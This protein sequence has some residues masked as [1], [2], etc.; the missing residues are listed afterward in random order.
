MR[1]CI[2]RHVLAD[3]VLAD[4]DPIQ[5]LDIGGADVNGSYRSLFGVM[6]CA[7]TTADIADDPSVDLVL[8]GSCELPFDD[9]AFDVVVSGQTFEHVG[10]FW[11]LFAE[12]MRVCSRDG[13]V[14]VIAPST[15]FEHRYPVDCYRFLPDSYASLAEKH[16][17]MLI[18][19]WLDER[20]PFCD[21]VGI[22]RHTPAPTERREVP[23]FLVAL[24]GGLQNDTPEIEIAEVEVAAGA[25]G[26]IKFLQQVHAT[27]EPRFYLEV[28][29]FDGASLHQ[30]RCPALGIDPDPAVRFKL[31]DDQRVHVALS[32]DAFRD[33]EVLEALG[34][35]DLVYIDGMHLIEN[36]YEDFCHVERL[37]HGAS[38]ILIDDVFPNHPH[39]ARR[40]RSSRHWTGD[41]WKIIRILRLARPD[42]VLLP[43]DVSPTGCLMVIGADPE[44]RSLW[45]GF[46]FILAEAVE[47]TEDPPVHILDRHRALDPADPLIWRVLRMIRD[48]RDAATAT[49]P[50][51]LT[52]LRALVNGAMP[53]R[54]TPSTPG[55]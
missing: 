28:G 13:I 55:S 7:Y 19:H 18:D 35:L 10:P 52:A 53:R 47:M 31:R 21:L 2:R 32:N 40:Q 4:R 16:G 14:V 27:L 25:L 38:V 33:P 26:A 5:V 17:V 8:D 6:P 24:D 46:D 1:R 34:P 45:D 44:N 29:V 36:A 42:L 22:F 51:D 30:A 39:Q 20:G 12:M 49:D 54:I 48:Q 3:P 9:G 41:V 15:G 11:K 37:A 43:V 23:P 50:V